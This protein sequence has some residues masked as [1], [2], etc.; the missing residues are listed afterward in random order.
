MGR[1]SYNDWVQDHSRNIQKGIADMRDQR[2]SL[3]ECRTKLWS[4]TMEP[5]LRQR[6]DEEMRAVAT[7]VVGSHP[8]LLDKVKASSQPD[9]QKD[10]TA[11]CLVRLEE[12][13][14]LG[15]NELEAMHM[16]FQRYAEH[17]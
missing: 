6:Q 16:V 3:H 13:L 2:R 14:D 17:D 7:S 4:V 5:L 1:K 12:E 9:M 8:G 11:K 15:R 10:L